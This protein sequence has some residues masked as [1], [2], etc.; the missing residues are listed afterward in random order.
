MLDYKIYKSFDEINSLQELFTD[1]VP[2]SQLNRFFGDFFWITTYS[3]VFVK[4]ELFIVASY[5]DNSLAAIIPFQKKGTT[6]TSL[7]DH[8]TDYNTI[9][10]GK[11]FELTSLLDFL[12]N[13][14]I[15]EIYLKSIVKE[16]E[17]Y[18]PTDIQK[19]IVFCPIVPIKAKMKEDEKFKTK[20]IAKK[21]M[22]EKIG[23]LEHEIVS[24][25]SD[26]TNQFLLLHSNWWKSKAQTGLYSSNSDI[27]FLN[28][29][30]VNFGLKQQAFYSVFYVNKEIAS[31]MLLFKLNENRIGYYF[32]GHNLKFK[33]F[34]LAFYTLKV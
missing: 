30:L 2:T 17:V 18:I 6:L 9:F 16:H 28:Q 23:E 33:N 22:V 5:K 1:D 27:D 15:N 4:D 31:M 26:S 21:V 29:I 34:K 25:N 3:K 19:Q 12:H 13:Q 24:T 32:G 7:C 20:L 14:G 8:K 11:Y 10:I